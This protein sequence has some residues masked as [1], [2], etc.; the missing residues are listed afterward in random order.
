MQSQRVVHGVRL[1]LRSTDST[2]HQTDRAGCFTLQRPAPSSKLMPT[3]LNDSGA[4][5]SQKII[6]QGAGAGVPPVHDPGR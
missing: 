2:R 4:R 1:A 5:S 3:T 6:A